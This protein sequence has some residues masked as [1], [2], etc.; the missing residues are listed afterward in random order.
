[1]S[2][3]VP[4]KKKG[5]GKGISQ[6]NNKKERKRCASYEAS[7]NLKQ[8]LREVWDAT[9]LKKGGVVKEIARERAV[10]GVSWEGQRASAHIRELNLKTENE[11]QAGRK[12]RPNRTGGPKEKKGGVERENRFRV[13]KKKKKGLKAKKQKEPVGGERIVCSFQ[14]GR[15]VT[16]LNAV[17]WGWQKTF[18]TGKWEKKGRFHHRR[19]VERSTVGQN[20]R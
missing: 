13:E 20:R 12:K 15:R 8:D 19:F 18:E 10:E 3:W 16:R 14:G 1:V 7:E 2:S 4:E 17:P 6:K 9:G 11:Q 5:L